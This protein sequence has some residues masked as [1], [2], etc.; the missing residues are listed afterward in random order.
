MPFF[1]IPFKK[2]RYLFSNKYLIFNF[3][4]SVLRLKKNTILDS[5]PRSST[6]SLSE[7]QT[8]PRCTTIDFFLNYRSIFSVQAFI[9]RLP[10]LSMPQGARDPIPPVKIVI[11]TVL[12]KF[13]QTGRS[14]FTQGKVSLAKLPAGFTCFLSSIVYA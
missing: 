8:W 12:G 9:T 2:L 4:T 3:K 11:Q 7:N 6:D 13:T 1:I 14:L 5:E 10:T